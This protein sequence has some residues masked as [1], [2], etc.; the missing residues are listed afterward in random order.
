MSGHLR[1]LALALIGAAVLF[2]AAAGE[3]RRQAHA[4]QL[5]GAVT[6]AQATPWPPAITTPMVVGPSGSPVVSPLPIPT[7]YANAGLTMTTA[8]A[9]AAGWSPSDLAMLSGRDPGLYLLLE[10]YVHGD[11]PGHVRRMGEGYWVDIPAARVRVVVFY[12]DSGKAATDAL[13]AA[14]DAREMIDLRAGY[15]A[16]V[17]IRNLPALAVAGPIR[18]LYLAQARV[19]GYQIPPT[20]LPG[21]VARTSTAVVARWSREA[22]QRLKAFD[23]RLYG[24]LD[25]YRNGNLTNYARSMGSGYHIDLTNTRIVVLVAPATTNGQSVEAVLRANGATEIIDITTGFSATVPLMSL[26]AIAAEPYLTRLEIAYAR[27]MTD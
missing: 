27:A 22:L 15:T 25:A 14:N 20:A 12:Y 5:N 4:P 6:G 13:L 7:S 2:T 10:A 26:P 17:P 1:S 16:S 23:S 11:L 21:S 9:V 8:T 24:L 18:E 19:P 3:V